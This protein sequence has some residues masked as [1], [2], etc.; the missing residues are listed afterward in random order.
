[1]KDE[2]H[3]S[4][5]SPERCADCEDGYVLYKSPTENERLREVLEE[6]DKILNLSD[7]EGSRAKNITAPEDA[8]VKSLCEKWGYGAVMDSAQRQWFLKDGNGC[9]TTGACAS[10]I[11]AV[12]KKLTALKGKDK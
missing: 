5:L 8:V 10:T 6:C 11:R 3:L 4:G 1:V 12:S 2:S 7:G 9:H